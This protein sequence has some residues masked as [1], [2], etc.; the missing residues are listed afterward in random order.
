[1]TCRFHFFDIFTD[2]T[3]AIV[4]KTAGIEACIRAVAANWTRSHCICISQAHTVK[5]KKKRKRLRASFT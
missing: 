4:V 3:K 1:M 2:G 5:K